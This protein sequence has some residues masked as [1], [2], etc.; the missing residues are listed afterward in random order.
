MLDQVSKVNWMTCMVAPGAATFEQLECRLS[1]PKMTLR[2]RRT[3]CRSGVASRL[4]CNTTTT[5][6]CCGTGTGL[7]IVPSHCVIKML[8][9]PGDLATCQRMHNLQPFV[10]RQFPAHH[11]RV[12]CPDPAVRAACVFAILSMSS[13]FNEIAEA[14]CQLRSVSVLGSLKSSW[15]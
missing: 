9:P 7:R 3:G 2:A 4:K 15:L 10:G 11:P 5:M 6:G 12:Q 14:E 13:F 8:R 1:L